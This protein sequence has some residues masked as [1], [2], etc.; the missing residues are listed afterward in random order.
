MKLNHALETQLGKLCKKFNQDNLNFSQVDASIFILTKEKTLIMILF[1][2]LMLE[3]DLTNGQP[4]T[5]S[6]SIKFMTILLNNGSGMKKLVPSIT[7]PPQTTSFKTIRENSKLVKLVTLKL[8]VNSQK[9]PANGSG[10]VLLNNSKLKSEI[11]LILLVLS[12]HQSQ[13]S[14]LKLVSIA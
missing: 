13:T 12:T 5:I 14:T 10:M 6:L 9:M 3:I 8:Q 2:L 11:T 1:Y 7:M 4:D